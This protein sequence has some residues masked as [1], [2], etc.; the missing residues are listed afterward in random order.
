MSLNM[1]DWLQIILMIV[2]IGIAGMVVQKALYR[3]II[4][5]VTAVCGT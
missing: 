3:D 1:N 2:F 5:H 4:G